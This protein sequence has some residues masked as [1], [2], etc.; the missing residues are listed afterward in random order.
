M[1][2][3]WGVTLLPLIQDHPEFKWPPLMRENPDQR[4]RSLRCDYHKDHDHGTNQCQGL[5]FMIE[6]L[7]RARHLRRF[8]RE[9]TRTAET[10]PASNRAIVAAEHSSEPRRTINFILGGPVDDQ[11]Q[12]RGRDEKCSA[13]PQSEPE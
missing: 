4:N 2:L 3:R 9:P 13:R 10:A 12:S 8:I 11:Y 7:I 1:D 6:R 5:K